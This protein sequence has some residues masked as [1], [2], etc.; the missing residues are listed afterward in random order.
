MFWTINLLTVST[1]IGFLGEFFWLFD[2]A[3]HFRLQFASLG[4]LLAIIYIY[5][6]K[7][8]LVL[9]SLLVI[10]LNDIL[11]NLLGMSPEKITDLEEKKIINS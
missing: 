3:S 5:K 7:T 2:L 4:L 11:K 1:I 6:L 10:I 8:S 9:Y